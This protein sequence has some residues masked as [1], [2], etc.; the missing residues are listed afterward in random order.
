[1][2]CEPSAVHLSCLANKMLVTFRLFGRSCQVGFCTCFSTLS[3]L[4]TLSPSFSPS[5]YNFETKTMPSLSWNISCKH[6]SHPF[7]VRRLPLE[8]RGFSCS[9]CSTCSPCFFFLSAHVFMSM[10]SVHAIDT[11]LHLPT[12]PPPAG[13]KALNFKSLRMLRASLTCTLH[14]FA[15]F[16]VGTCLFRV[17]LVFN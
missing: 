9:T 8:T 7:P 10:T 16:Y 15:Q 1:M 14:V 11:V 3:T 4:S 2:S 17:Q 6:T 12:L 5:I 13:L